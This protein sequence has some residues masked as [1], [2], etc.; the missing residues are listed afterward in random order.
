MTIGLST[1]GS[2]Q[3]LERDE[4]LADAGLQPRHQVHRVRAAQAALRQ[5]HGQ[6][7]VYKY[8]IVILISP[9]VRVRYIMNIAPGEGRAVGLLAG[10]PRHRRGHRG[11]LSSAAHTGHTTDIT[12]L[13]S[14]DYISGWE[15]GVFYIY[16]I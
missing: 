13:Q 3:P 2:G 14:L 7:G 12:E 6:T 4:G 9:S 5:G 8:Q 15:I 11:H 16:I 10:L 1:G